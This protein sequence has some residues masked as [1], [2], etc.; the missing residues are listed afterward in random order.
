[1]KINSSACCLFS[2]VDRERA[3]SYVVATATRIRLY[4]TVCL[5]MPVGRRILDGGGLEEMI[6]IIGNRF[7]LVCLDEK[8]G[9]RHEDGGRQTGSIYL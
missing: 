8:N 7:F 2:F 6:L 5:R 3:S 1:M 9:K 4:Y